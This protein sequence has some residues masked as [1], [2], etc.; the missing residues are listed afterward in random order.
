MGE[1][2]DKPTKNASLL[3]AFERRLAEEKANP[4]L[5]AVVRAL[6]VEAEAEIRRAA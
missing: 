1:Q 4:K 3:R 2:A 6:I 5:L